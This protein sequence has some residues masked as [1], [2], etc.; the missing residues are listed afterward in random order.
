MPANHTFL[1]AP[2]D[3]LFLRDARPM[4]AA[5]AG[6]GAAWP[7][8]DQLWNALVNAFHRQ[9]PERQ[10]WEHPH[11]KGEKDKARSSDRFGA[12]TTAGPFPL[13]LGKDGAP[14][15]FL[16][17][18]L[19]LSVAEDGTLHPMAIAPAGITNLPQPLTHAFASTRIGKQEPPAWISAADFEAYLDGRP[20][21]PATA[22]LYDAERTIGIAIDPDTRA[23]IEKKFYQ[24][25]YLRLR[26]DVRLAFAA[27]CEIV[28]EGRR[29]VDVFAQL[30]NAGTDTLI[31]GGQQGVVRLLRTPHPLALPA[32]RPMGDSHLL[33][34]VLLSP[35]VF[36]AI[37][38]NP[39]KGVEIAHPGGWLPSWVHPLTGQV[40]LPRA[41][42]P[43]RAQFPT[44]QEWRRTLAQCPRFS[45][46]LVAAR[47]GKPLA[48]SGWD[49]RSGPKPTRLA[50]P[51][52]SVYVFQCTDAAECADL[53][54]SLAWNGMEGADVRNRRS[55][56]FGEK[57]FGLGACAP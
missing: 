52:G 46:R 10:T 35:A 42:L 54:R 20:F 4:G 14:E 13:R 2:R 55:G 33:K 6:L 12:L 19:D 31:L 28:G 3:L 51:A 40:M 29:P 24:A 41:E 38:V 16:P 22:E 34:W 45:A 44:R 50:V 43:D 48:F 57:G 56:L 11:V 15:L 18:P 39:E 23:T 36:P 32:G 7:R 21:R 37:P 53:A 8:S 30:E 49:L 1:L 27:A 5:D 9:W 26:D 25:E 47:V 17:C